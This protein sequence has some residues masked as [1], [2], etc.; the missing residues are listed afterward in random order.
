MAELVQRLSGQVGELTGVREAAE[1]V[2][3]EAIEVSYS[4]AGAVLVLDGATWRVAAGVGLRPLEHRLQLDE[5]HWLIAEVARRN[6][7]LIV[8]HTDGVRPQLYAA[9]LASWER[10]LVATVTGAPA[11]LILARH[12]PAYADGDLERV[13][14]VT[15]E[16]GPLLVAALQVRELARGLTYLRDLPS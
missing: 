16:A 5:D 13:A 9:P 1:A 2:V 6:R 15:A 7:R 10:L 4:S 12:A 3:A 11:L 8:E 14:A